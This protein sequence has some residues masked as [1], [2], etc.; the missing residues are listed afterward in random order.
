MGKWVFLV[1]LGIVSIIAGILAILNPFPASF[2][3]V[4]LAGW[5]FLIIGGLQ[6]IECFSTTLADSVVVSVVQPSAAVW[7]SR[8]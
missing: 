5:A 6:I 7:T 2:V 1:L 3:A 4:K 8:G